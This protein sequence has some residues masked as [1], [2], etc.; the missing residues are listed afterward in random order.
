MSTKSKKSAKTT[1]SA[2]TMVCRGGDSKCLVTEQDPY[3]NRKVGG[4]IRK[5][6]GSIYRYSKYDKPPGASTVQRYPLTDSR[7]EAE[8]RAGGT[9]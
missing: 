5:K 8:Q 1:K 6:D 4:T 3:R 2:E 7:R 9:C